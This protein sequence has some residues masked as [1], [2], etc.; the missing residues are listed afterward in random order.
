MMNL[1]GV[2]TYFSNPRKK[3]SGKHTLTGLSIT[4]ED[5]RFKMNK[6]M[7][8]RCNFTCPKPRTLERHINMVHKK[9]R[10]YAC[11]DCPATFYGRYHMRDHFLRIHEQGKVG[12]KRPRVYERA[13]KIENLETEPTEA[14]DGLA[15]DVGR[16]DDDLLDQGGNT[17][18]NDDC[19]NMGYGNWKLRLLKVIQPGLWT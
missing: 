10:P 1:K 11:P 9:V 5:L 19:F 12:K 4:E 3:N 14:G 2:V 6:V 8:A 15:S 7:C 18:K 13:E 16:Q 17:G